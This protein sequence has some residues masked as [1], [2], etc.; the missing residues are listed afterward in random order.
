MRQNRWNR[1]F[2]KRYRMVYKFASSQV[3][4]GEVKMVKLY[5]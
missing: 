3:D 2:S 5:S 4:P 1:Q